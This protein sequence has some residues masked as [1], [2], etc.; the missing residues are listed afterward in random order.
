MTNKM[1]STTY[2]PF[3]FDDIAGH[4]GIINELKNRSKEQNFP[5]VML[6][7][8]ISGSGKSSLEIGRASCRE[9]V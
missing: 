2:R 9:R 7:S 6:F 4:A 8:G 1:Y 3:S 5:Q